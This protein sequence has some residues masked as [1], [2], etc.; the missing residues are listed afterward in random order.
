MGRMSRRRLVPSD[1]SWELAMFLASIFLLAALA[2]VC[3]LVARSG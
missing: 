3:V 1:A 2:V